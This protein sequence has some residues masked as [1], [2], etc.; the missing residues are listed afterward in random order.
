MRSQEHMERHLSTITA[1]E[2]LMHELMHLTRLH[3]QLMQTMQEKVSLYPG[4][5]QLLMHLYHVQQRGGHTPNQRELAQHLRIR[6]ATLTVSLRR[7]EAAGLLTRSQDMQDARVQRVVLSA[8]GE[9][10]VVQFHQ[11]RSA[12]AKQLFLSWDEEKLREALSVVSQ[13]NQRLV[14]TLPKKHAQEEPHR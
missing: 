9:A 8:K 5:P 4:Q 2:Q 7:M 11:E 1:P 14:E 10:V 13:I 3:V 6:P 12:M